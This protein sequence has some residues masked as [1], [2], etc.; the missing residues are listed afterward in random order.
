MT[1]ENNHVVT[2][3]YTL[4]TIEANGEKTFVEQSNAEQPLT[5]LYGVGMMIPKFEQEIKGLTAGDKKSFEIAPAEA[6]GEKDPNA[7]TQLPIDMFKD[8]PQGLPP[9]GAFLPLSDNQ[10]NN[11]TAV[12]LEVTDAE[13]IVD[14]NHPMAGK[15]L[16]FDVEVVA[17]RPATEEEL[18]HGHAHGVDGNE[19][20]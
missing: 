2:L 17:S 5:F 19:A 9:V 10:G 14:L 8:H 6:Y 15:T 3:N 13:I 20:H 1:I 16:N 7:I 4:H 18:S 11:F 12:V